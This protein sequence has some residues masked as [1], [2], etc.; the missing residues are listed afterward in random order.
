LSAAPQPST[1]TLG[2][3]QRDTRRPGQLVISDVEY[4]KRLDDKRRVAMTLDVRL[5]AKLSMGNLILRFE[6]LKD[7]KC[8]HVEHPVL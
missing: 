5:P 7:V 1:A 4:E 2:R 6:A 8:I 3:A